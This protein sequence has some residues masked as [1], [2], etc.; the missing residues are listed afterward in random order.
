[1]IFFSNRTFSRYN[2][3]LDFLHIQ[4][5]LSVVTY[6]LILGKGRNGNHSLSQIYKLRRNIK[7]EREWRMILILDYVDNGSWLLHDK[8]GR[9]KKQ[10]ESKLRDRIRNDFDVEEQSRSNTRK[11][12]HR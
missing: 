3:R 9:M 6:L 10:Y 4:R 7:N 8:T 1:M 2:S 5:T 12:H 11:K